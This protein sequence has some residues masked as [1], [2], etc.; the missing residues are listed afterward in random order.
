[1]HVIIM[2]AS[3]ASATRIGPTDWGNIAFIGKDHMVKTTYSCHTG[4]RI[5][6]CKRHTRC[7]FLLKIS[8][9]HSRLV[10]S[11]PLAAQAFCN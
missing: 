2:S 9:A 3:I 8:I 11:F 6:L 7:A 10:A 1:M 5:L 4:L